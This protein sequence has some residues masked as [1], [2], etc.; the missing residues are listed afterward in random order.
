MGEALGI[1]YFIAFWGSLVFVYR[2]AKRR[3]QPMPL[4]Q[5]VGVALIAP[6]GIL[7]YIGMRE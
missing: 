2:D 6:V 4:V 5:V 1:L 7:L 3:G